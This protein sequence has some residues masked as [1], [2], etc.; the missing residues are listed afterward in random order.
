[1]IEEEEFRSILSIAQRFL[2]V[3]GIQENAHSPRITYMS[4]NLNIG[5]EKGVIEIF[6]SGALVFRHD[7]EGEITDFYDEHGTWMDEF[8]ELSRNIPHTSSG[9]AS[10]REFKKKRSRK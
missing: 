1:M 7:P 3:Y 9:V 8:E 5:Y 6:C 10:K 4:G 2:D